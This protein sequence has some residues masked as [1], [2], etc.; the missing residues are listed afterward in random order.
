MSVQQYDNEHTDDPDLWP[1]PHEALP[2]CDNQLRTVCCY[3]VGFDQ[4]KGLG[5]ISW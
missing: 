2:G 5:L 4:K 3:K 1:V